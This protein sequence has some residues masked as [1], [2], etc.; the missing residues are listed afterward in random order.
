MRASLSSFALPAFVFEP[1]LGTQQAAR[2]VR[3]ALQPG[4][5]GEAAF[6]FGGSFS[7]CRHLCLVLPL[8]SLLRL[9]K[10]LL[11]ARALGGVCGLL[12]LG[13]GGLGGWFRGRPRL[14]F[15]LRGF[16]ARGR[17]L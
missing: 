12:R 10:C 1:E 14:G 17:A 6:A 9:R 13:V 3:H 8:R 11:H 16:A 2:I 4:F 7:A 5:V 15:S